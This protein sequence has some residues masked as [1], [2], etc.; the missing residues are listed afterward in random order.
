MSSPL[1]DAPVCG[2][3]LEGD[4]NQIDVAIELAQALEHAAVRNNVE[5]ES[6]RAVPEAS[7]VPR[8]PRGRVG[9]HIGWKHTLVKRQT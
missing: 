3:M 4:D 8:Y 2:N 5:A 7:E 1:R 6:G 9:H